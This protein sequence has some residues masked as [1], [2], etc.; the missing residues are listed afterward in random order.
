MRLP[1]DHREAIDT[2]PFRSVIW[3]AGQG[4]TLDDCPP[5]VAISFVYGEAP[6]PKRHLRQIITEIE[7]S[8][9][10]GGSVLLLAMEADARDQVKAELARR[11]ALP[12]RKP[13]SGR[14]GT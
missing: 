1:R 8:L 4:E 5:T 6:L 12:K 11:G 2:A 14:R 13:T 9:A 7:A 10:T 3:P